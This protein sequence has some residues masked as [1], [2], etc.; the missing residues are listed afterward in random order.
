MTVFEHVKEGERRQFPAA[1]PSLVG[2]YSKLSLSLVSLSFQRN[3]RPR[4]S[5]Q[6]IDE[7]EAARQLET[8]RAA[9]L[10]EAANQI[11]LGVPVKPWL[12]SQFIS[13]S[14]G[15]SPSDIMPRNRASRQSARSRWPADI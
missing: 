11:V 7:D 10:A 15:V 2:P 1:S 9:A 5:M 14:R 8:L 6:C 13:C 4:K 3:P 12:T